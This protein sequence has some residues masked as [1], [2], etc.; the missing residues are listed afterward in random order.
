MRAY[1]STDCYARNHGA[2][3]RAA[4]VGSWAFHPRPMDVTAD[5]PEIIWRHGAA[6]RDAKAEAQRIATERGWVV[7]E[8]MP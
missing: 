7:V 5:S 6:F 1:V 3:P 2:R 4:T 8:V